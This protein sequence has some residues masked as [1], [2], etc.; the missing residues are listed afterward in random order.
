MAAA[1]SPPAAPR[2][3]NPLPSRLMLPSALRLTRQRDFARVYRRG[4][5]RALSA[6]VLHGRPNRLD[7]ARF[8]FSVSKKLGNAV[9]RNRVKR[10]LRHAVYES[11]QLF[12]PGFDYVL[13]ARSAAGQADYQTLLDQV[14][15]AAR[16]RS[17]KAKP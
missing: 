16:L 3:A 9:V 8:G 7:R 4:S 6:L 1:C 13:V 14:R 10:R 2:V 15:Q 17:A 11:R 5:S 12:P